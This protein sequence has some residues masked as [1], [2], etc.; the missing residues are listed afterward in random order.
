M[1][2]SRTWRRARRRLGMRTHL[3]M[4]PG[5]L[6]PPT[7]VVVH[8]WYRALS[9]GREVWEA[10]QEASGR[11]REHVHREHTAPSTSTAC[12]VMLMQED[13]Q[14]GRRRPVVDL[15]L[16]SGKEDAIWRSRGYTGP[17]DTGVKTGVAGLCV[18]DGAECP[19]QLMSS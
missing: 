6:K 1:L 19:V 12:L 3:A 13:M 2:R 15:T 10:Q 4:L 17:A 5:S 7:G 18:C 14:T 9:Q 11:I 16:G 8:L